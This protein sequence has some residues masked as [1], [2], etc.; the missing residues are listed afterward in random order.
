MRIFHQH[1]RSRVIIS[2]RKVN[3]FAVSRNIQNTDLSH[4]CN[5]HV[6]NVIFAYKKLYKIGLIKVF[7]VYIKKSLKCFSKTPN[8]MSMKHS[9]GC[10]ESEECSAR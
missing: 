5:F 3:V 2:I 4:I 10:P 6:L 7:V 1:Y 8:N 9:R